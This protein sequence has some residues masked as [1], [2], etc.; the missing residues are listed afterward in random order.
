MSCIHYCRGQNKLDE[1]ADNQQFKC[2]GFSTQG[3]CVAP[4]PLFTTISLRLKPQNFN[5]LEYM[6]SSI[7]V[8]CKG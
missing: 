2:E 1:A 7:R 8:A 4:S 5:I 3:L 6:A